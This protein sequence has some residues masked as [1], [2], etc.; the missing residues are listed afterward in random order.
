[1]RHPFHFALSALVV[2]SAAATLAPTD[3]RAQGTVQ[4]GWSTG[5]GPQGWSTGPAQPAPYVAPQS[6]TAAGER[7][8]G[9]H[10]LRALGGLRRG[11]RDLDRCRAEDR[12]SRSGVHGAR[13]SW[14]WRRRWAS[15]SSIDRACRAA[16]RR[17]SRRAWPSEP[18]KGVGIAS[19]QFVHAKSDDE[20]G[21]RGF[22]RSV[23]IGSTLGTAA[24]YVTAVT[25]EPSPKTSMLLGSSVALGHDRRQHVRLRR[26]QR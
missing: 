24:G 17:R 12:R 22:A 19:Y 20:W 1:M 11:H 9:R 18:A 10:A 14:V 6:G 15:S 5:T 4:G 26:Q 21:F 8:R 23:F 7:P 3:A 2:A 16:C 25:M 13:D